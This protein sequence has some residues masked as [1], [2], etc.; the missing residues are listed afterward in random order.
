MLPPLA[1]IIPAGGLSS[2]FGSNKLLADLAGMP[3]ATRTLNAFSGLDFVKLI[4]VPSDPGSMTLLPPPGGP[5]LKACRPGRSR[6]ES[7]RNG[8]LAVDAAFEWIAIHD[9]ARPLVSAALIE[10]VFMAALE[11]GC[12]APALPVALTI[13]QATGPLPSRVEKTIPRQQLWAMQTP[14]IMRRE[15]L[16]EAYERC[17]IDLNDVTDDVQFLELA[18]YEVWLVPGEERN[19]KITTP[20]DLS[21]AKAILAS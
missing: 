11:H 1:V 16:L 17:P 6:A 3:V 10:R 5:L 21:V 4:V 15:L 14:Q 20:L 8:L 7:V 18:G 13:K 2:R 9:A 19:L 12:A